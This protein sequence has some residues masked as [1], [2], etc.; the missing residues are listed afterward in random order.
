MSTLRGEKDFLSAHNKCRFRCFFQRKAKSFLA[1]KAVQQQRA[2][3]LNL[4]WL[5]RAF[6]LRRSA[7]MTW[8]ATKVPNQIIN[9]VALT[10]R[11][12]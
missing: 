9:A 3:G 8:L 7:K 1:G 10:S 4:W 12:R 11:L 5:E 2:S 6:Q